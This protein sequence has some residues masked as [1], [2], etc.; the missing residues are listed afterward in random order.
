MERRLGVAAAIQTAVTGLGLEAVVVGGLAVEY[1]THG[2]FATADID[3]LLPS[4]E[5]V[6]SSLLDLGF[7]SGTGR[8]WE[9]PDHNVA[10]ELPGNALSAPQ[11]A[12][13]VGSPIGS[14]VIMLRPED[15]IVQRI[16]EF[17]ATGYFDSAVQA[18]AML[19]AP[20]LDYRLLRERIALENLDA[21]LEAIESLG[22]EIDTGK[23]IEPHD[24]HE[25][26]ASARR[27]TQGL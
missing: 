26:A 6:R 19:K 9:L 23:E 11:E 21:A 10:I 5:A 12:V 3:L 14:K 15:A 2:E 7:E 16:H 8:H 13:A 1:W 24:V 22:R 4:T 27:K 17:F 18:V 25:A 20:Q